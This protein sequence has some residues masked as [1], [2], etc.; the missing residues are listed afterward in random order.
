MKYLKS[1]E[2]IGDQFFKTYKETKNWLDL[3][4]IKNYQINDNL[5]VDVYS[6]TLINDVN[7]SWGC[8]S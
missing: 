1:Y 6:T 4:K 5:V 8:C 2:S 7:L 3:M